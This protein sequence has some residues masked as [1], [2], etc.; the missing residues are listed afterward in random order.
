MQTYVV[1]TEF[2]LDDWEF[3]KVSPMKGVMRIG[4]K[5]KLSP[6]YVGPYKVIRRIGQVAYEVDLP[7]ELVA[8]HSV[9]YASMLCNC[10]G[11]PT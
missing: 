2:Q 6:R 10:L 4:R 3:L 11:N 5:G 8:A 1:E 7:R 9:F